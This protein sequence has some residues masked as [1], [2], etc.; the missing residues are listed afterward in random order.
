VLSGYTLT[1]IEQKIESLYNERNILNPSDLS[2]QNVSEKFNVT[3]D[4]SFNGGPQRAI[5]DDDF[6]LI[7]LDP[8]S[9]E[10]E[11][12]YVFFHEL[13]HPLLHCGNQREMNNGTFREFQE[14]QAN[15]FQLYAAVPFFMLKQ[16]ELPPY[17]YQIIELIKHVFR[18]PTRLAK[19]RLD[20]IK[21]RIFQKQMDTNLYT[22]AKLRQPY[23][24]RE[25]FPQFEDLFTENEIKTIFAPKSDKKIKLYFDY[26]E[27][28]PIP[29]WYCIEVNRGEINWSKKTHLFPID[30]EYELV[31]LSEFQNKE[32]DA[33]A[34]ELKLLPSYPNEF[35]IDLKELKKQ[36]IYF[37]IDPYNV[38]RF[39]I[40]PG[41]LEQL[42]QL[43]LFSSCLKQLSDK[44]IS[45]N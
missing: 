20:Q 25:C 44:V 36:L 40:D 21:R 26:L 16:L 6:S 34:V 4:F 1:D 27:G 11:Q 8:D 43:D 5:W 32:N 42:L 3:V 37:D 24:L 30:I 35:A 29:I 45:S 19:K 2:I 33:H 12:R 10:E 39:I 7:F 23:G 15:Q 17:D 41:H 13:G 14:F 28:K 38:R 18:V 22:I 31:P 9:P